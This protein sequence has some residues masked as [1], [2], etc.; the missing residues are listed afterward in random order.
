MLAFPSAW[1]L[2]VCSITR[3]AAAG[4]GEEEGQMQQRL[5]DIKG[6]AGQDWSKILAASNILMDASY[7]SLK[8]DFFLFRFIYFCIVGC[9]IWKSVLLAKCIIRISPDPQLFK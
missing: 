4:G 2:P 8:T 9:Q 1:L 3:H 5:D 7:P 6:T